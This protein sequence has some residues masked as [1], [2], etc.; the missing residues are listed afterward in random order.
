MKEVTIQLTPP[1]HWKL[2]AKLDIFG[3]ISVTIGGSED[4]H[5]L[6]CKEKEFER[7]ASQLKHKKIAFRLSK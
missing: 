4:V 6:K 1:I 3:I 7:L 5:F 2:A